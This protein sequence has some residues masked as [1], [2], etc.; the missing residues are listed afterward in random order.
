MNAQRL[1]IIGRDDA[2]R[3]TLGPLPNAERGTENTV[4][5]KRINTVLIISGL[6]EIGAS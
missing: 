6:H 1:K 2:P 4:G 5:D 3:R